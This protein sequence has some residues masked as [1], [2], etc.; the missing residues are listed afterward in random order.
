MRALSKTILVATDGTPSSTVALEAAGDIAKRTGADFH[1]V[2]V[3]GD[4]YVGIAASP[5]LTE[6][7]EH[8]AEE[9]AL[10]VAMRERARAESLGL[11]APVPHTA[12]G[13]RGEV[14]I[15]TAARLGA[16]LIVVGARQ[17]SVLTDMLTTRV[18]RAVVGRTRVPVLVVPVSAHWPPARVIAAIEDL[19]DVNALAPLAAWLASTL[20]IELH[21]THVVRAQ[22][23]ESAVETR[24][25]LEATLE[26]GWT[27]DVPLFEMSILRGGSVAR[28]LL[29]VSRGDGPC[30]LVLGGREIRRW[31]RE[32]RQDVAVDVARHSYGPLLLVP[33]RIRFSG[34]REVGGRTGA[35]EPALR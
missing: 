18:S 21:F 24:A 27:D 22:V 9:T 5:G 14:V 23:E 31:L 3:W 2:H 8:A 13:I 34:T 25:L 32:G 16:D 33:E 20:G 11:P 1:L 30:I 4:P 17:P 28:T 6:A 19:A 29:E 10:G 15:R 7:G 12:Q 26:H 35:A